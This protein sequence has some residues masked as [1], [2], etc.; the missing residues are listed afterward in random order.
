MRSNDLITIIDYNRETKPKPFHHNFDLMTCALQIEQA[1][2]V[3]TADTTNGKPAINPDLL[4]AS[5]AF[6]WQPPKAPW[7]NILARGR[8]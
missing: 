2:R 4:A 3:A 1:A 6:K 8:A 7:W 5:N